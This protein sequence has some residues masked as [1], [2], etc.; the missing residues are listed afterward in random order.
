MSSK[1]NEK[2][3][4][5]PAMDLAGQLMAVSTGEINEVAKA[6]DL[7]GGGQKI[8]WEKIF[9]EPK[10]GE[11]Y[12]IKFL[13]NLEQNGN[14]PHNIVHRSYYKDLPDPER[15]GK[16]FSYIAGPGF[17]RSN[18][19]LLQLWLDLNEQKKGGDAIAEKKI[20][21]YLSRKQQACCKIQ[22]LRSS[23]PELVG[24]IMLFRF[25]TYGQNAYIANLI[26]QRIN[27]TK[28]QI[29]EGFKKDNIFDI[30]DSPLMSIQP[31]KS[32][33]AGK[34]GRDMSNSSWYMKPT[35][36]G[37][38]K[39][40]RA[41][42]TV[43]MPEG[44]E[45]EASHKFKKTDLDENGNL[46]PELMPY[47]QE[48]ARQISDPEISIYRFFEPR[49]EGDPRNTDED[50]EYIKKNIEKVLIV[51]DKIRNCTLEELANLGSEEPVNT[52]SEGRE[53]KNVIEDSIPDDDV[54]DELKDMTDG[55]ASDSKKPSRSE[56]NDKVKNALAGDDDL[57]D[58]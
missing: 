7:D 12:V 29:E 39:M 52:G 21:K 8:E 5:A 2:V 42:A 10:A 14:S 54:P 50:N 38:M 55:V 31:K 48:L 23:E 56:E 17:D 6:E 32:T 28:E 43:F 19:L 18:N 44:F 51:R 1:E 22:I 3:Q 34:E 15:R 13:P 58:F 40:I 4:K 46:K 33:F 25:H 47:L 24:K 49:V 45:G 30:F 35:D 37:G 20:E 27:P 16:T 26:N 36:D 41:G 57:D 9:F 53:T 11:S